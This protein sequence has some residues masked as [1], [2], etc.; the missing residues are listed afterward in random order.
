MYHESTIC[1][2]CA[3]ACGGC[4]WSATFQ[5]VEGWHAI[6]T[7]IEANRTAA[8]RDSFRVMVCPQFKKG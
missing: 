6:K 7:Q 8:C 5:P 1:W 2:R 4:S 3:N